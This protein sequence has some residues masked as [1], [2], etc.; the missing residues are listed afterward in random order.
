MHGWLKEAAAVGETQDGLITRA[1]LDAL[2]VSGAGIARA[3][4]QGI[5]R[6]E[7]H[8]VYAFAGTPRSWRQQLHAAVLTAGTGALASASCAATLCEFH[9]LPYVTFEVAVPRGRRVRVAGVTVYHVVLDDADRT[10]QFGVPTTTFERT[11]VDCTTVLSEFQLSGNLDHGLR[12]GIASIKRLQETV[13]RLESGPRRRLA[14]VRSLLEARSGAYD[15][16]GSRQERRIL[17]L[18]VAAGLPTPVQQ[19][20]VKVFGKTYILDFAYPDWKVFIEFY[21]TAWHGTPS[22]S[23]YDSQRISDLATLR[24]QPLIFTEHTPDPVVVDRIAGTL[25]L[26]LAA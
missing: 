18:I 9:H 4:E 19:Y 3:T 2:D 24:W 14:I 23:V 26:S 6:R 15:P 25:G 12:R 21:G 20:R 22:A 17:D 1:Q 8:G 11:L 13:D 7:R 5:L 16:G 10:E